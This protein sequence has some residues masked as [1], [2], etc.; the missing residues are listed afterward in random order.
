[1]S[2]KK[3]GN[4]GLH[5]D[6]AM[7][8]FT[9]IHLHIFLLVILSYLSSLI[10]LFDAASCSDRDHMLDADVDQLVRHGATNDA[11][12]WR[13]VSG[14]EEDG[15]GSRSE[16]I[17]HRTPGIGIVEAVDAQH[18]Y[19]QLE[20]P[21]P[22]LG[23]GGRLIAQQPSHKFIACTAAV[24]DTVGRADPHQITKRLGRASLD[25]NADVICI[26]RAR[27]RR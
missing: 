1:M 4:K 15:I 26:W 23:D 14:S 11:Y 27:R 7:H 16:L 3:R 22:E 5:C 17:Q 19:A 9:S 13:L 12:E 24:I 8:E 2:I 6:D 10:I 18:R 25:D 20:Q 21:R